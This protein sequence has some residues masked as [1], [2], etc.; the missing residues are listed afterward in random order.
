MDLKQARKLRT[1]AFVVAIVV[2]LWLIL[3]MCWSLIPNVLSDAPQPAS[4]IDPSRP[5]TPRGP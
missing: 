1:F 3:S 4:P 2:T 5:A